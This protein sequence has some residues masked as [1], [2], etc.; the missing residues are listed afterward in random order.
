MET[1]SLVLPDDH[2]LVQLGFRGGFRLEGGVE[3]R[4]AGVSARPRHRRRLPPTKRRAL[5]LMA[6]G[7]GPVQLAER[8]GLCVEQAE[9]LHEELTRKMGLDRIARQV[10]SAIHAGMI[11]PIPPGRDG[12]SNEPEPSTDESG[13]AGLGAAMSDEDLVRIF[14]PD[15]LADRRPDRGW[16]ILLDAED[17]S[18]TVGE[19][20][21]EQDAWADAAR[22]LWEDEWFRPIIM[23]L[24]AMWSEQSGQS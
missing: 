10:R 8:L 5:G 17:R 14:F 22:R 11:S 24:R 3:V 13:K 4:V 1:V 9:A 20:P 6:F 12:Q 21:T 18:R 2:P 19:G 23:Q 15:S 7:L 16:Q